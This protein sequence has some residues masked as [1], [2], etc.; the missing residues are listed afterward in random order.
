MATEP[1]GYGDNRGGCNI[2]IINPNSN[3]GMTEGMKRMIDQKFGEQK[4][5]QSHQIWYFLS[6]HVTYY[7]N[8]NK[9]ADIDIGGI[10]CDSCIVFS[11]LCGPLPNLPLR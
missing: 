1:M 4:V 5:P 2:L 7:N 9:S 11:W 3:K 6:V 8:I 10:H